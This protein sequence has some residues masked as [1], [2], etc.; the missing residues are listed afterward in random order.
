MCRAIVQDLNPDL[1]NETHE[2]PLCTDAADQKAFLTVTQEFLGPIGETAVDQEKIFAG[3]V[4][5][6]AA[7]TSGASTQSLRNSTSATAAGL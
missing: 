3:P 7:R 4:P 1:R 6:T 5:G 2:H